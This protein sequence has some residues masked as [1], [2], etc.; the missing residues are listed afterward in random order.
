MLRCGSVMVNRRLQSGT[1][2]TS[3]WHNDDS[4]VVSLLPYGG[5]VAFCDG[6]LVDRW[7]FCSSSAKVLQGF[8]KNLHCIQ[9]AL[10]RVCNGSVVVPW[11]IH[12]V[13]YAPSVHW[14]TMD[15]VEGC[16]LLF[17]CNQS[18][19]TLFQVHFGEEAD[20]V[21]LVGSEKP[22]KLSFFTY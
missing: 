15:F 20:F 10:Q 2:V 9:T 19:S 17:Y 3:W 8:T 18:F 5:L 7:R 4:T 22:K 6:T 1:A 13:Q 21:L 16:R 11:W 14:G 12:G